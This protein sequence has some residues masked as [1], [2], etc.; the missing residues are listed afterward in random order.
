MLRIRLVFSCFFVHFNFR[1]DLMGP[2]FWLERDSV[3]AN[4]SAE[5]KVRRKGLVL[6]KPLLF[7]SAFPDVFEKSLVSS[8]VF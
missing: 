3:E 2:F 7:R 4:S 6:L 8:V 5:Q 1:V